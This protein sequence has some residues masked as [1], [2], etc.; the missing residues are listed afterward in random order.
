MTG[1]PLIGGIPQIE[2]DIVESPTLI[3]QRLRIQGVLVERALASQFPV[4]TY[5]AKGVPSAA[6]DVLEAPRQPIICNEIQSAF[7]PDERYGRHE[8]SERTQWLFAL[9]LRFNQEVV[10]EPFEESVLTSPPEV[11]KD[12][13]RGYPRVVLRLI[14]SEPQHP[15]QQ[16]AKTGTQVEFTFEAEQGRR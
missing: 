5:D 11:P 3:S 1:L 2:E 10:L 6:I 7:G 12:E 9:R 15:V 13:S 16:E 14:G 8:I 4:V